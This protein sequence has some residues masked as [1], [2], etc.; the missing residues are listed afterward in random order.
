MKCKY[1]YINLYILLIFHIFLNK[2]VFNLKLIQNKLHTNI[3]IDIDDKK[4]SKNSINLTTFDKNLISNSQ[5]LN[6][7]LIKPNDLQNS[8]LYTKSIYENLNLNDLYN[9]NKNKLLLENEEEPIIVP[10]LVL[11]K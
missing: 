6:L 7:E 9:N 4:F 1:I 10:V 5:D 8:I 2:L 11:T 3:N